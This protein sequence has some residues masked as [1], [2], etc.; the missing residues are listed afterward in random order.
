MTQRVNIQYSVEL[1]KL[2]DTVEL[3]YDK[4]RLRMKQ[5]NDSMLGLNS[6]LDLEM[7]DQID[8]IRLELAQIDTELADI[9][10]IVKGY[11]RLKVPVEDLLQETIDDQQVRPSPSEQ[12]EYPAIFIQHRV[13]KTC[14]DTYH[15]FITER[16]S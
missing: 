1:D 11:L 3:L 10:R 6:G 7:I 15:I 2:G 8:C 13:P 14:R 12:D 4:T 9:D 5:L 16:L